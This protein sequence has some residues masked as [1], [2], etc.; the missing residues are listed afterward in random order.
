MRKTVS[1]LAGLCVLGSAAC[2][3]I[4]SDP[5]VPVAIE[6]LPAQLPFVVL[7]DTLRDTLGV[8]TPLIARALNSRNE[9]IPGAAITFLTVDPQRITLDAASGVVTGVDTG[10]VRVVAN[11]GNLQSVP[12]TLVVALRP[13]TITALSALLDS[14]RFLIGT[15]TRLDLRV[16]VGH[17]TTPGGAVDETVPVRAYV[18]RFRIVDPPGLSPTDTTIVHLANDAGRPSTLD[19][20]DATGE[21]KRAVRISPAVRTAPPDSIIVEATALRP[22]L[23]H[24]PG[25]PIRFIVRIKLQ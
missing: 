2:T 12:V 19:T 1:S 21:A 15:D 24:V 14:V 23:S 10:T 8:A 9:V 5:T 16:R 20:T 17:D 4:T 22:D 11:V 3:E 18:V 13:D 25:S 7:G 6:L